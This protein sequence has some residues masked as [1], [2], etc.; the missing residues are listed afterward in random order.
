[1]ILVVSSPSDAHATA[2][3]TELSRMGQDS[4]LLDLRTFPTRLDLSLHYETHRAAPRRV[5]CRDGCDLDLREVSAVWWRRPQTFELDGSLV[6]PSY[7]AFAYNECHEA[8]AGLW[9]TLDAFWVNPPLNDEVAARKAYQLD[10][11]RWVGLTIP[12]TLITNDPAEARRFVAAHRSGGV[13]YKA[14]S[15]TEQ[16]WRETRLFGDAEESLLEQVRHAPVIFQ[17]YVPAGVDLRVTVVG[18]AMFA[19]AIYS[20]ETSYRFDFRIDMN[21]ARVEP[22]ELPDETCGGL[23]RLMRRLGLQ[24]G[25]IDLRRTPDGGIVFLEINPAGQWLFIEDRTRQPIT[26]AM[27]HLLARR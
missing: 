1:M 16:E 9:H 20:Q 7:R 21:A 12:E 2:V 19:A 26:T 15:A 17:E 4:R 5:R 6:R 8:W 3:R 13:I 25:A 18:E 24:Y 23:L 11:A 14:F 22:F 10:V 27:A